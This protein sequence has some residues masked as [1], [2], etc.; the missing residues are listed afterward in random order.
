MVDEP[1]APWP[2]ESDVGEARLSLLV[3]CDGSTSSYPLPATGRLLIGRSP[4]AD[5]RVEHPSVSREHAALH[6]G[7]ELRI[8]DLG[9]A[10]GTRV[11][12]TP[13]ASGA[14]VEIYP[15]DV[16]DLGA[17]LLVVQ[18]RDPVARR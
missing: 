10:N 13:L 6:V 18:Y 14:P 12:E 8:E 3:V 4:E 7:A 15:D 16:V 5:V 11:R 2:S 17:V 1:T 9:S